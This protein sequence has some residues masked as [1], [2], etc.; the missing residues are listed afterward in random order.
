MNSS[1]MTRFFDLFSAKILFPELE[2]VSK[3][4]RGV[5]WKSG[6]KLPWLISVGNMLT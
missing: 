4:Q 1:L 2:S 3:S 6:R 5:E